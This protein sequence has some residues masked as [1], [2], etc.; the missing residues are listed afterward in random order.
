MRFFFLNFVLTAELI[1]RFGYEP[2]VKELVKPLSSL[3][4]AHFQ[5]MDNK[6]DFSD[7]ILISVPQSKKEKNRVV[8][9]RRWSWEKNCPF[10]SGFL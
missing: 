7:F 2:F 5:L 10:F 6:P 3:I 4:I 8:L 1:R 9:T